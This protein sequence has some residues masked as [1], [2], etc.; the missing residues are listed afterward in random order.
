MAASYTLG[1]NASILS[2]ER[3]AGLRMG[4]TVTG[5]VATVLGAFDTEHSAMTL[6][7]LSRRTGLPLT[8][9]HRLSGELTRH[10]LLER[11]DAQRYR[12]GLRL[13]EIASTASRAVDLRDAALPVLQDL[14]TATRENVQLAVLDGAEAVYLERLSGAESVHVVTRVG[15]RLPVHASGVGLVLLAYAPIEVQ[16]EVLGAPLARFTRHTITDPRRLRRVLADVRRDGYVI[17]DR[18]VEPISVSV[19]AP[20]RD[21]T[22]RVVAAVSVV[23]AAGREDPRTFVQPVLAAAAAISR[24]L[25]ILR[26]G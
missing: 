25:P 6:S 22:R 7:E 8:T 17:S 4:P 10:G 11:D 9:V 12:V 3:K 21:R 15:S 20:V 16:D 19:G 1:T 18:Q 23:V 26:L 5:R 14:Y 13:W 2:V 24:R